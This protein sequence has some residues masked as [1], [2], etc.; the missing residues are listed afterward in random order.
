M[1]F[2][3]EGKLAKLAFLLRNFVRGFFHG[4][5]DE[6]VQTF[7]YT[8]IIYF[9]DAADLVDKCKPWENHLECNAYGEISS[10]LKH[11]Y[12]HK[13]RQVIDNFNIIFKA[14]FNEIPYFRF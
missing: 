14:H 7:T 1:L 4:S 6:M 13:T 9:K 10:D 12:S 11:G 3:C 8:E 5:I 2:L